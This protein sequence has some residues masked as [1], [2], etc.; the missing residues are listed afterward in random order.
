VPAWAATGSVS[1]GRWKSDELF[2]YLHVQAQPI[3]TGLSACH[4]ERRFIPHGAWLTS[5][6]PSAPSSPHPGFAFGLLGQQP[7]DSSSGSHSRSY[8]RRRGTIHS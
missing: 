5:F 1:I 7:I 8:G 4:A 2:R 6:P 3:M